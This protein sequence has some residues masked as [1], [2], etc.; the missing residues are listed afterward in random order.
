MTYHFPDV[1]KQNRF[2]SIFLLWLKVLSLV[3]L[4]RKVYRIPSGE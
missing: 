2:H 3:L 4:K 1:S